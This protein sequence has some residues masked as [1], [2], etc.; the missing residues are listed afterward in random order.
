MPS[1]Y[2]LTIGYFKDYLS[3]DQ[4]RAILNCNHFHIANKKIMDSLIERMSIKMELL[5][6]C[7][8]LCKLYTSHFL[9]TIVMKL[10]SG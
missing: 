1:N 2:H 10:K 3:D 5:E 8:Q 7:D 9:K 4:I 6:F